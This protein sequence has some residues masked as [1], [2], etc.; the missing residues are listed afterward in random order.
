[1]RKV[2]IFALIFVFL[3]TTGCAS[4]I[5]MPKINAEY[6][7][8][9]YAPFKQLAESQDRLQKRTL[10][11]TA[12]G[13]IAGAVGG[14][15][16]GLITSGDWKRAL[17]GAVAGGISGGLTGY[18]IAKIHEIK[19]QQKR[20][21]AY[22][23]SMKADLIN[24]TDVEIAALQSLKCYVQ[25]FQQLQKNYA[26]KLITK[27]EFTKRYAEIRTG[28]TEIGRITS[29]SHTMLVQRDAEFRTALYGEGGIQEPLPTVEQRRAA[30]AQ[31]QHALQAK[32]AKKT[33]SKK[34]RGRKGRSRKVVEPAPVN[35]SLEIAELS[36]ELDQAQEEARAEK[37]RREEQNANKPV[38]A[39][40]KSSPSGPAQP[41][42]SGA[43]SMQQVASTYN[44]YPDRVLRM[45]TVEKQ[46]QKTLEIM[47]NAALQSGIDMV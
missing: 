10:G 11:I 14:A 16:I 43:V 38:S 34:R 15:A 20:M 32:T 25:E 4:K 46:R 2:S 24:A 39:T 33:V 36:K 5:A 41:A 31:K 21:A 28:I 27:E 7:P 37:M 6:Y 13:A 23:V 42:P 40:V 9:C 3:L 17:I 1:M 29:D 30:A 35:P 12:A 18:T 19:D 45:E 44:E 22:Q 8:Q 26:A 47:N